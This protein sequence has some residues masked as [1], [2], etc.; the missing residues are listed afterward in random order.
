MIKK[1]SLLLSF[2]LLSTTAFASFTDVTLQTDYSEAIQWTVDFGITQGYGN[3]QWGPE[4]CVTRAELL[5][6]MIEHEYA[7]TGGFYANIM[8]LIEP[9]P[10]FT[11]VNSGD[12][13]YDYVGHSK[14]QNIIE[15][16]TDGTFRPNT[17]VN[18]VEAMKI[19]VNMMLKNQTMEDNGTPL[20]YDDKAIVDMVSTEWYAKYARF[21]FKNRLVGTKHTRFAEDMGMIGGTYGIRFYPGEPMTRKEV[22]NMMYQIVLAYP[23]LGD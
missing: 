17:C 10:F 18:R 22:A 21:L 4:N 19:A 1:I 7:A 11:D 23:P 16:Y 20:Y 13:F 2:F 8:P 9:N 12:W 14:E 15:G 5:K 6:M 3:G